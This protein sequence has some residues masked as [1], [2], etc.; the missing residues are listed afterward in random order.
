MPSPVVHFDIS[1]PDG[2]VLHAFYRE[3]LGWTVEEKGPGYALVDTG[4]QGPGGA[5]VESEAAALTIGLS[6]DGLEATV[7]RVE[8]IG[9][10][11]EMPPTDNGWVT[12]AVVRDPAGNTLT[13]IQA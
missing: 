8:D 1:G 7:A 2:T 13:L 11:V 3:L 4:G 5:I 9:G 6:V 12:K 10:K